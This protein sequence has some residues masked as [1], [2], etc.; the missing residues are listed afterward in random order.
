MP[1]QRRVAYVGERI[2]W[3]FESQKEPVLQFMEGLKDTPRAN[4]YSP[5]YPKHAK[6]LKQNEMIKNLVFQTYD[7][8]CKRQLNHFLELFENMLTSTFANPWVFIHGS[9]STMGK[10]AVEGAKEGEQKA[11][12]LAL[13]SFADTKERLPKEIEGRAETE[14]MLSKWL[15][16]IPTNAHNIDEAV[17]KVQMLVTRI[18]GFIRSQ[19]CDQ[20]ELFSESFFKLPMMRRLEEDMALMELSQDDAANHEARRDR[21]FSDIARTKDSIKEINVCL[22]RLQTFKLRCDARG[23]GA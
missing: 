7:Q 8:A 13:S 14:M 11:P 17:D 19:V 6:L 3:F 16:D 15:T 5:L 20:V 21:L 23:G 22:S 10:A 4:I 18:Y 9:P 2:K 12:D 1:L